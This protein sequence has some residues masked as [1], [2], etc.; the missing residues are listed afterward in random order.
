[1]KLIQFEWHLYG[2]QTENTFGI[3]IS[4]CTPKSSDRLQLRIIIFHLIGNDYIFCRKIIHYSTQ[5]YSFVNRNILSRK[6]DLNVVIIFFEIILY[7]DYTQT[8]TDNHAISFKLVLIYWIIFFYNTIQKW[9]NIHL[10]HVVN[11]V[12][13]F[14]F[15]KKK[16]IECT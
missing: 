1:M 4:H 11:L 7:Y 13:M 16:L 2:V 8:I 9:I 6:I 10:S 3:K 14:T 12:N 15:W 5:L